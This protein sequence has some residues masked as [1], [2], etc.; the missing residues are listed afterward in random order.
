MSDKIISGNNKTDLI[1]EVKENKE[2]LKKQGK[3]QIVTMNHEKWFRLTNNGR[4]FIILPFI[5][6]F[7]SKYI[8]YAIEESFYYYS[9]GVYKKATKKDIANLIVKEFNKRN[10]LDF[11]NNWVNEVLSYI[12]T[13]NHISIEEFKNMF[14]AD[15]S[16]INVKNGIIKIDLSDGSYKFMGH[17]PNVKSTIQLNVNYNQKIKNIDNWNNFL[18]TS[19]N[20]DKEKTFLYE[21]MGY[22]LINFLSGSGQNFYCFHGEG[23]NGKG[24]VFR[25]LKEILGYKNIS[26]CKSKFLTD[27]DSQNQF[28]GFQFINKLMISVPETNYNFKDLSLIKQLSGGD[29]QNVEVKGS[30]ETINYSFNGKILISTND[31]V[32][33]FDTSK[34]VKRRVKFLVMNNTIDKPISNLDERLLKEKES[35]F[36]IVL[37]YLSKFIKNGFIHTLPE[38]HFEIFDKYMEYSNNYLKF[39][40]KHIK[41]GGSIPKADIVQLFN[42]AYGNIYK[43]KD[44]LFDLFEKELENEKINFELRK[45]RSYSPVLKNE[46][47]TMSYIGISYIE[48]KNAEDEKQE[49]KSHTNNINFVEE[50]NKRSTEQLNNIKKIIDKILVSRDYKQLDIFSKESKRNQGETLSNTIFENTHDMIKKELSNVIIKMFESDKKTRD[51]YLD[52]LISIEPDINF[53]NQF[54]KF[55]DN[56]KNKDYLSTSDY[57]N[58]VDELLIYLDEIELN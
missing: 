29:S 17:S 6:Y 46:K 32:K 48:F 5:K 42:D 24:T 55:V 44:K 26:D 7:L 47:H 39:I 51:M 37:Q 13:N 21:I 22:L 2:E 16:V 54:Y 34:G 20:T 14:N 33:F 1:L 40:R 52:K 28:F 3:Y 15:K 43:D 12:E 36:L 56:L 31:K 19:L 38:S 8:I 27:S 4:S 41:I 49:Q 25:L 18:N 10:Y 58:K 35:I 30:N 45:V 11:K 9:S 23:G 57:L 53:N 50:F